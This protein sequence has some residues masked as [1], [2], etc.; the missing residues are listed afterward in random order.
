VTVL[1][2][3]SSDRGGIAAATPW[4]AVTGTAEPT[5][6]GAK[7]ADAPRLLEEAFD[8]IRN[9]WWA[10]GKALGATPSAELAHA[11][12]CASYGSDLGI[13]LAW[14]HLADDL[15][16][17]T[18]DV[19]MICDDPWLFRH[20]AGRS[21]IEAG[22]FPA[23][24]P[25][26]I[27]HALRG[28]AARGRLA[29]RLF[30]ANLALR[31]HRRLVPTSAPT[32]LVYGHPASR[33]DG[34]DAYFGDLMDRL[35]GLTRL[36]HT[37][38][39]R[40]RA[41]LLAAEG[42]ATSLHAWG[43]PAR[44]LALLFTRWRPST[45]D[46]EGPMGWLVRRA[47]VLEGGRAAAATTRWQTGCQKAWLKARRPPVVAWP[48]ENHPWERAL[49]RTARSL[50]V[51]TVG[52]QHTVIGRHMYNQSPASNPDGL[53]SLPDVIVCNGPAYRRQL[54]TWGVPPE[55]LAMGGAFR[56]APHKEIAHD[57]QAPLF[58]ALSSDPDI[59]TQ[60][61]TAVAALA[62]TGRRFVV[63]DHPMYPFEFAETE[64]IRRTT[65][66]LPE[67]RALSG[68]LYS[69]GTVGLEALL[70]G[71]PTLRFRPEGRIAIDILPDGVAAV[72]VDAASLE[73]ALDGT[74]PP[75][76]IERESVM[77]PVDL[78]V[79]RRYLMAGGNEQSC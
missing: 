19:L 32:L 37:D 1:L 25:K 77:A 24:W 59:S 68:V 72:P 52:Y 54:E 28:I 36:L 73:E 48:W 29:M 2:R 23:L 64:T 43:E 31:G 51:A 66:V 47:A 60:M 33:A 78:A 40:D 71:L 49:V 22:H 69:T 9:E 39:R 38:C 11:P 58:V 67:H 76:R 5:G 26:Q 55:R 17:R 14:T 7:L 8:S 13:M 53:N 65:Q 61:M 56:L 18:D 4:I 46:T 44:I 79:W 42:R 12:T 74:Q 10:L 3:T 15:G 70:A 30:V 35:S 50:G 34:A 20:L 75:A 27:G 63:K 21:G 41:R 6:L 57:A 16:D 45:D 62:P